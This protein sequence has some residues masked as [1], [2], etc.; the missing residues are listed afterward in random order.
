MPLSLEQALEEAC[1]LIADTSTL[2]RVVLS[3]RRRNMQTQHERIDIRPVEIKGSILL[4][5]THSDGR[6][7]T[8]K[9]INA[10]TKT[11]LELLT[12]GYA[13]ITVDSLDGS[14]SVRVTKS[15]D[16]QVHYEKKTL[17]QDFA[18]DK[19]K[20]RLL[21][22]SDPFLLEVG[23]TDHK[24][25]IKPSKNDKYKQVEEFLRLLA[26]TLN[27]AIEA[28]QIE[29]PTK[30]KPLSIVDLGCGHAYLTFAAHQYLR[31]VGMNVHV[32]GI[33]IRPASRDRNNAIATSL[34]I[35]QTITF[36]AEEIA[37]TTAQQADIAI[38]LHACDTAT[39]DA[40][41]WAVNGGA[42]LLLIAPCCHH[43]IQKQMD[44]IP[45]PWGALTKFGVM[46]ERM[47]DLLT[48]ALRAQILRIVGYRVEVI[49]F[50]GGEH[51]PRN[52]MIRAV[53]T[54]AQPDAIDIDRYREITS[55]WGIV[56]ALSKKIPT[57]TIG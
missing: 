14:M 57:F 44:Q 55:Q 27:S 42:K 21:D 4:Q 28:G 1:M 49:E 11:I 45:E 30:E 12:S 22:P 5:L 15:G 34:G 36:K 50:I 52:I 18:H 53:K 7:T 48:D 10:E 56:P 19:K 20:E 17:V 40:I 26:P 35:S 54:G 13:N 29:K 47:G 8:T 37:T 31:S 33:D 51:T 3:G 6:A 16:A 39:D 25:Q 9:N 24:G 2:V 46:K 38:A 41:A 43:D 32:T 23:I